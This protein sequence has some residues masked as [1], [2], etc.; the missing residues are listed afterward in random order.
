MLANRKF[1]LIHLKYCQYFVYVSA[2]EG[3]LR[4]ILF[5]SALF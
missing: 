5:Y 4:K 3:D 2:Q 1:V